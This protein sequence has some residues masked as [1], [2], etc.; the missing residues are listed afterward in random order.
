M[1]RTATSS[2]RRPNVDNVP[3]VGSSY[4]KYD[5]NGKGIGRNIDEVPAGQTFTYSP[6]G[7][8]VD[9]PRLPPEK[10]AEVPEP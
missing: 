1:T 8:G 6:E 9:V 3:R 5:K 7:R 2:S 10:A 4:K